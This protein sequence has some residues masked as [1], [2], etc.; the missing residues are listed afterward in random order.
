MLM[1]RRGI[2]RV[3]AAATSEDV[4]GVM[5]I[6]LAGTLIFLATVVGLLGALLLL[7]Y[8][9][10]RRQGR[11][12]RIVLL[13]SLLWLVVYG[14]LLVGVSLLTPQRVLEQSQERCFD[15]MCFSVTQ[16]VTQ[17][18]LG[19]GTQ[20]QQAQDMF[21]VVTVQLRNASQRVAQK[22]DRPAFVLD[23]AHGRLYSPSSRG[24]QAVGQ[25]PTWETRLQPGEKQ[26]RT[27]VFDAPASFQQQTPQPRLGITEGRWPTP[28]IIGDENSPWHRITV[29][30]L[31]LQPAAHQR[32]LPTAFVGVR[33][34]CE[35][36]TSLAPRSERTAAALIPWRDPFTRL[37]WRSAS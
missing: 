37:M 5:G 35:Q 21:Y 11:L 36:A 33:E 15:E 27:L 16:A 14:A 17:S 20:K 1:L 13:I 9:V 28:L 8:A 19:I 18:T 29:I 30:Q 31:A 7:G 10:V 12:A 4:V 22:P 2:R 26:E 24:Q 32:S 23:D 25:R 6:E 34:T 3:C